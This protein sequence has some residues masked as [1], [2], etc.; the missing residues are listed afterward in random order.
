MNTRQ[1]TLTFT[2]ACS[3]L[4]EVWDTEN[5]HYG[6][7]DTKTAAHDSPALIHH[8]HTHKKTHRTDKPHRKPVLCHRTFSS[9]FR[10]T[11]HTVK[12]HSSTQSVWGLYAAA[13]GVTS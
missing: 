10:Y 7:T 12:L 11:V 9:A 6:T 5:R 4:A 8:S 13:I 1:A 3:S 2:A